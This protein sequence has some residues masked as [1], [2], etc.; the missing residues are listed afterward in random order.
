MQQ[1]TKTGRRTAKK[2]EEGYY[3]RSTHAARLAAAAAHAVFPTADDFTRAANRY[4]DQCDDEG[5]LYGEAGLC[6]GLSQ[7]NDKGKNVTLGTLRSWYDGDSCA[8][9]QEAVQMA[10]L[11]IQAQI[12][13]D[14]RYQEKGGIATRA[15]FLQKQARF[16]GY[17]DKIESKNDSTVRILFGNGVD[18]SDFK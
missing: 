4:F 12:E 18:E 14:P 3:E 8:W 7:F 2:G 16:G 17:Q 11:R 15:I 9:L 1:K 5:V 10:Y 13:H 6:L